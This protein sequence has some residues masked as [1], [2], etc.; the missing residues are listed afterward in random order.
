METLLILLGIDIIAVFYPVPLVAMRKRE[1]AKRSIFD[2]GRT[3]G[4][5]SS[6][7]YK[8]VSV[9]YPTVAAKRRTSSPLLRIFLK[10]GRAQDLSLG[11]RRLQSKDALERRFCAQALH[12]YIYLITD[13]TSLGDP[14]AMTA[15]A[16][17]TTLHITN[18]SQ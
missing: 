7:R 1:R 6:S 13:K 9:G 15:T 10:H 11:A 2:S 5:W 16:P 18:E 12:T 8:V 14:G 17:V 4:P 3:P